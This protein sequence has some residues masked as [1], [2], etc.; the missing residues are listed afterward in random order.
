MN[1]ILSDKM[2]TIYKTHTNDGDG[3]DDDENKMK[4]Y[5]NRFLQMYKN[6]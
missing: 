6:T 4:F 1:Q 5:T 3:D 2:E